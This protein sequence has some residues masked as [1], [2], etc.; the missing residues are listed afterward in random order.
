MG[1]LNK[2]AL[3]HLHHQADAAVRI[4]A[5]AAVVKDFLQEN[6]LTPR[7]VREQLGNKQM[8]LQERYVKI[9]SALRE[10]ANEIKSEEKAEEL[11]ARHRIKIGLFKSREI[12]PRA[13]S[14][15]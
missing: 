9:F 3:T 5:A 2:V 12:K 7:K 4:Q 11:L 14:A 8:P 1:F 15:V 10:K 13:V 6:S